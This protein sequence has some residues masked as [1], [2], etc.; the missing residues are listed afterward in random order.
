M[1]EEFKLPANA[2][3]PIMR[4]IAN[5]ANARWILRNVF[6]NNPKEIAHEVKAIIKDWLAR[7]K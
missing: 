6:I 4:K 5:E 1:K 7:T 3:I 2:N